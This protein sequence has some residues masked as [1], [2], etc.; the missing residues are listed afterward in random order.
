MTKAIVAPTKDAYSETFIRDHMER[1][2][3]DVLRVFGSFEKATHEGR[4][5]CGRAVS[6]IATGRLPG[7]PEA[8]VRYYRDQV[9]VRIAKFWKQHGVDVVMAEFATTASYMLDSTLR[10]RVPMV[11]HCHGYDVY[12]TAILQS[13]HGAYEQLFHRAAAIV[14]VSNDMR[15]QVIGLGADRDK[16]HVNPCGVDIEKFQAIDAGANGLALVSTSRFVE[17]KGPHLTILAFSKAREL[18]PEAT[19][20]IVGD[21][22]LL[23]ACK[24]LCEALRL[25]DSVRL[26]GKQTHEEVRDVLQSARAFVLHS[27]RAPNGDSEGSPV[28]VLEASATGLP[29]IATAHA[30]IKDTMVH[31]GTGL[32][33][34]ELDIEAMATN[35]VAVLKDA[36]LA[37]E[38]GQGGRERVAQRFSMN[39]SIANLQD[40]LEEAASN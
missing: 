28:A 15:D 23:N 5:I 25:G 35:M 22:P 20:T 13:H 30:G 12:E 40:I 24:Q 10:A 27:V 2:G 6:V 31:G 37:R 38:L 36:R 7:A 39:Q 8:M 19:L 32:L 1:L 11:A 14:V 4:L 17:K 18:C 21:G 16:V 34:P 3:P 26:P 9:N 29:V 33:S